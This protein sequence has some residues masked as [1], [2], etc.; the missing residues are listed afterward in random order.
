MSHRSVGGGGETCRRIADVARSGCG[1]DGCR[2]PPCAARQAAASGTAASRSRVA[3]TLSACG[4]TMRAPGGT[5]SPKV[6]FYLGNQHV[7]RAV[8]TLRPGAPHGDPAARTPQGHAVAACR[9]PRGQ[10]VQGPRLH[11][12]TLV[13]Q[14]A[15]HPGGIDPSRDY[16]RPSVRKDRRTYPVPGRH[17][18]C[19]GRRVGDLPRLDL[20]AGELPAPGGRGR[21]GTPGREHPAVPDDRGPD[22]WLQPAVWP[23]SATAAGAA[24]GRPAAGAAGRWAG[25]AYCLRW[26]VRPSSASATATCRGCCHHRGPP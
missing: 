20:A 10:P 13:L 21:E 12:T 26:K 19:G 15:V 18:P 5:I 1:L 3:N 6:S 4:P 7:R 24:A 2:Y 11:R 16:D 17:L 22:D 8:A 9:V 23:I 14:S 25:A